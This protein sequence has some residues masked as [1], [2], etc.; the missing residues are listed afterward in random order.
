[1]NQVQIR[2]SNFII[3]QLQ[4]ALNEKKISKFNVHS[5]KKR[6]H[7][8]YIQKDYKVESILTSQ[9]DESQIKIFKKDGEEIG[10]ASFV[11]NK[12]ISKEDFQNELN[13]AIFICSQSK[14]K[15]YDL[16]SSKKEIDDKHIK[17][18]QYYKKELID[19]CESGNI[20]L[21]IF[22]KLELLKK[23]IN[24]SSTDKIKIVLN[25]LEFFNTIF[26][27][28]LESSTGVKKSNKHTHSYLEFVLTAIDINSKKETE[29]IVYRKISD[30][31]SFDFQECFENAVKCVIDTSKENKA[32]TFNGKI[33][34]VNQACLD[35]FT[36]DLSMNCVIAQS[37]ARLKHRR[38]TKFNIGEDVI[39][40]KLDKLTIYSNPLNG[41][42]KD[43]MPYDDDGISA[44]KLCLIKDS[45]L[46]NFAASKK[47]ANYLNIEPTGPFGPFEVDLGKKSYDEL[48]NDKD[49]L[50]VIVTFASF[51]PD[52]ISGD[53]SAEIRLGYRIENGVKT[54]FK[55]GLFTGNIFRLLEEVELSNELLEGPSYNGPK[56]IKFHKGQI[57]GL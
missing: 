3:E 51:A 57:I 38:L 43:S 54:P 24:K 36:P 7:N 46:E 28:S 15:K 32:Q 45:K 30:I 34:L 53:F 19:D 13:E 40:S 4:S 2:S 12:N 16:E 23:I 11:V 48:L 6:K 56:Q 10:E 8:I 49:T 21:F 5:Y 18:E 37:V 27:G 20:N 42:N 22:E 35:F 31:Y 47:F 1:M 41:K 17:Y 9:R 52:M 33:L 55:G 14:S 26:E 25:A 39:N 44:R 50:I 29:H